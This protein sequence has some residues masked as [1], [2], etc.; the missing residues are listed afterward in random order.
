MAKKWYVIHTYS[1][2]EN[3]VKVSVQE[4]IK[5]AGLEEFV[6][7]ILV[8]IEEVVEVKKGKKKISPRKFFPGYVIIEMEMNEDVWYVVKNTP[9]VTGFLGGVKDPTPLMD[10]EVEQLLQQIE[11]RATRLRPKVEFEKGEVV[12]VV[13]GPF[14]NFTGVI[15]EVNDERGKMKVM[16]SIFGRSTPLEVEFTQVERV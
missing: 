6:S 3:N 14:T 1:G 5:N 11:G 13:Q 4:R 12:R 8:P 16:V 10:E 9:K 2:F 7:K 15:D